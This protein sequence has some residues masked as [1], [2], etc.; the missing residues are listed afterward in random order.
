MI[1]VIGETFIELVPAP[2]S[3]TMRVLPGGS[4]LNVAVAAARLGHP[5]ALMARFSGDHFGRLLRGHAARSGVDLRAA[6][7]ADEP[8]TLAVVSSGAA[9]TSSS[10]YLRGT[11][12][13]QWSTAEL[14]RIPDA[15]TILHVGPIASCMAPGGAR[16][17]AAAARRRSRGALVCFDPGVYPE[18]LETPGRGRL[19]IERTVM[20]A[21]V[22]KASAAGAGWLYPGRALEDVAA[23][24][25]GLG[26]EL[27]VITCGA[28]GVIA[29]RASRAV[30]HR[31]AQPA[32]V[33]DT[34]GAGDSFTAALLGGLYL[35]GEGRASLRALPGE[36]L[37][38]LLDSCAVAAGLTCG[39]GVDPPTAAELG[40]A[41]YAGESSQ[42][43]ESA[44]LG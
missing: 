33:V 17:L 20:S 4:P 18:I 37:A 43:R 3:A 21:D 27:V 19:L 40:R 5:A 7:E 10:F 23:H 41:L 34:T 12:D 2:D 32:R 26:P 22:V 44:G 28:D 25:L 29:V 6:P 35:L 15:T 24:W 36:G 42:L 16:I 31:P 13:W 39:A 1:T 11:A 8:A 14:A 38:R 9:R 30:L